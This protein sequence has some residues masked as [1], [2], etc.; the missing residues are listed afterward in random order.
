MRGRRSLSV[1]LIVSLAAAQFVAI[2]FLV[3][4][5]EFVVSILG[6]GVSSAVNPDDW[7]EYRLIALVQNSLA[8]APDARVVIQP[9]V[10][11]RDYMDANPGARYAVFDV[12]T[13][14][15]LP[16]SSQQL[17][18]ALASLGQIDALALKFRLPT[19]NLQGARGS[20]RLLDTPV[21]RHVIAVYGYRFA[22]A[23]VY[24]VAKLFLNLHT[25]IVIAPGILGAVLVGW[26]VVRHGLAPLRVAAADIASIDVNTLH[27]RIS[28]EN[29]PK[30]LAPF[31]EAVNNA[32]SRLYAGVE[33]QRR[34]VA[35]AAHELRTPIAIMRAHA[36]NPDD[37]AFRSDMRRDI[38]RVQSIMEQLLA[39]ARLSAHGEKELDDIDLGAAVLGLIADF[40]PLAIEN[41]RQISFEPPP[42]QISI[43]LHKWAL[44]CVVSNLLNNALRAEPEGGDIHVRVLE[45]ALVEV[46]DHGDGIPLSD[47][48]RIFE[49]FWRRETSGKGA[50][51]G[52]AISKELVLSMGGSLTVEQTPG[53]GA[54]FRISLALR[55]LTTPTS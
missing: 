22:W 20:L 28:A 23:D 8:R 11:L 12:R 33:A 29:A 42:R 13:K 45:P 39:T 53:G 2:V 50:G 49:P 4:V 35:N 34:F 47:M 32:L 25:A 6:V 7:D 46:V 40:T 52:L 51:L 43:R 36:D 21:G 41:K 48:E 38:R 3:P 5:M 9:T 10:A 54:T 14:E 16:G 18:A 17:V 15:A 44:E 31:F 55:Q 37:A 19:D 1:R 24:V 26:I 27:K 30:E